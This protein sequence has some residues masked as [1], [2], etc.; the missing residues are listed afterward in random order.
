MS[1]LLVTGLPR[2]GKSYFGV[3]QLLEELRRGKRYV[4]TNLPLDLRELGVFCDKTD[5]LPVGQGLSERIRLLSPA[6]TSEFWLY[7]PEGEI[8]KGVTL[9]EPQVREW[10]DE[11][12]RVGSGVSRLKSRKAV[13]VPDFRHRQ[14]ESYPGVL[15]IIDEAHLFFD[16][17]AWQSLGTDCSYFISQH[18]HMRTDILF[19]TQHPGKLAKRLRMDLE[20][21][22]VVSNLGR[23]KG[24]KGVTVPGWFM[25]ETRAGSPD[26]PVPC[27]AERGHFKLRA[28]TIGKLYSTSAGV[29]LSGRVDTQEKKRGAHWTKWVWYGGGIALVAV[30]VPVVGLRL[31]GSLIS[32]TLGGYM[33]TVSRAAPVISS[34]VVASLP[35]PVPVTVGSGGVVV[36]GGLVEKRRVF[37]T[38]ATPWGLTLSDG[39]VL[40][41]SDGY[42]WVQVPGGCVVGGLGEFD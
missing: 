26:D 39:R 23:V 5:G 27:E 7:D 13:K 8:V 3:L 36:G 12:E 30:L 35:V 42:R 17:H 4:C 31:M 40:L 37:L 22:T 20:E 25:R 6:E 21:W 9:F 2:H 28:E 14:E 16:A 10:H 11:A 1:V 32:G 24:W 15:Y 29:G 19:I 41:R 18:G 33:R 38:G 34:N